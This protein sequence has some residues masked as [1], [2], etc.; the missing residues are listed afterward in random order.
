MTHKYWASVG[1]QAWSGVRSSDLAAY[2]AALAYNFLLALFP[3]LLF[4]TALLGFLHLPS[5]P[6]AIR[7]TFG[8]VLPPVM[9]QLVLSALATAQDSRNPAILSVGAAG[10]V[11]G[12]SGAFR[13]LI[14]AMNHAYRFS[15]RTRAWWKT[16]ALSLLL[17]LF[18]GSLIVLAVAITTGGDQLIRWVLTRGLGLPPVG[19]IAALLRWGILVTLILVMLAIL[20][21]FLPDRRQPLRWLSPG[22]LVA[23][24]LWV[25]VS[26]GFS[27]YTAHFHSYNRMYGSLGAVILLMLYLYFIGLS[28]LLGAEINAAADRVRQGAG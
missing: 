27:F 11:W 13:Q 15:K 4:L 23:L 14:D 3:L 7:Q 21:A 22:A 10:F 25:L 26:W 12:M 8:Q 1:R 5:L 19:W 24:A 28:L 2:A 6:A 9:V 17:G 18:L 20:Y 16:Y